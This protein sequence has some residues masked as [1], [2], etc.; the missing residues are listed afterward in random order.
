[1]KARS[2]PED[3]PHGANQVEGAGF[4][5]GDLDIERAEAAVLPADA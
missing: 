1:M 2:I 3:A 5:P 4:M